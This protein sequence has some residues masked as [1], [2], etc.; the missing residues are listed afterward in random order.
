MLTRDR[1]RRIA[2]VWII[3]LVAISL[4]PYRPIGSNG[5]LPSPAHRIE[6]LIAFV[7]TGVLLLA[8]SRSRKREWM[9]ALSVLCLATGIETAQYLLYRGAFEWWDIRDDAIGFVIAAILNRW[10]SVGNLLLRERSI[11]IE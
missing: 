3:C 10:T 8:L 11:A 7:A 2:S 9:A 1:L 6:H 5:Q 4:Q